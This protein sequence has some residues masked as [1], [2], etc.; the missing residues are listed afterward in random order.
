MNRVYFESH[1]THLF[2]EVFICSVLTL[3]TFGMYL[4]FAKTRIRK[5]IWSSTSLAGHQFHYA[6]D[7]WILFRSYLIIVGLYFIGVSLFAW[8]AELLSSL[9]ASLM[10]GTNAE[11]FSYVSAVVI[12]VITNSTWILVFAVGG[13]LGLRYLAH[14]TSYRNHPVQMS[15][16]S[17]PLYVKKSF[18]GTLLS[19]LTL[20]IYYPWLS[21]EL[22][23]MRIEAL[24]Y[25][26]YSFQFKLP[27]AEYVRSFFVGAFLTIITFGIYYPFFHAH[28]FEMMMENT[29]IGPVRMSSQVDRTD[30]LSRMILL[31]IL[32]IFTFGIAFIFADVIFLK[33]FLNSITVENL[34][35][36]DFLALEAKKEP[37]HSGIWD[38][39]N[40]IIGDGDIGL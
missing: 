38:A 39:V 12:T 34:E 16:A 6:G 33:P 9:L 32:G 30:L 11:I 7:A 21:Y 13:Y 31:F 15:Q 24:S 40:N 3:V 22:K 19:I 4:P 27:R 5:A 2:Y 23:K 37:K 1:G 36:V 17:L 8:S 35:Q 25:G 20:G 28:M 10:S 18:V 29:H 14:C 26:P